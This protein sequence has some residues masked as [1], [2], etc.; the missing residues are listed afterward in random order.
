MGVMTTEMVTRRGLDGRQ[1]L[2][3]PTKQIEKHF[4]LGLRQN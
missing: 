1:V 4:A 2:V 3:K